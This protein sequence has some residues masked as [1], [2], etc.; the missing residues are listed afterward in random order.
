MNNPGPIELSVKTRAVFLIMTLQAL[1]ERSIGSADTGVLDMRRGG[2][3]TTFATNMHQLQRGAETSKSLVRTVPRGMAALTGWIDKS[4]RW[5]QGLP[6]RSVL[7]MIPRLHV[8]FMTFLASRGP[9]DGKLIGQ[10]IS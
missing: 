2:P 8:E 3:M 7:G 1:I 6:S 5:L 4:T 10:Q 9:G